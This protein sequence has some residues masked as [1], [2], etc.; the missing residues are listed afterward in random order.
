MWT[1]FTWI[2]TGTEWCGFVNTVNNL[3]I[4][5]KMEIILAGR[6]LRVSGRTIVH[7]VNSK[8][9]NITGLVMWAE[10]LAT[11]PSFLIYIH[12]RRP[13]SWTVPRFSCLAIEDRHFAISCLT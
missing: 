2:T 11:W 13:V 6:V 9:E 10:A 4:L 8:L 5:S 12:P 3:Q 1:E 7:P